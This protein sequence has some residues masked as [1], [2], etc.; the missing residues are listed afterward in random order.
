MKELLNGTGMISALILNGVQGY[1]RR[2]TTRM[3]FLLQK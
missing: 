1:I 3:A 2:T